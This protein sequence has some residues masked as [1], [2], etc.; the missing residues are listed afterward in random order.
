MRTAERNA[1]DAAKSANLSG[2]LNNLQN[3]GLSK[4][5]IDKADANEAYVIDTNGNYKGGS[6]KKEGQ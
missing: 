5:R 3:L 2:F 6:K 4:Y 1:I